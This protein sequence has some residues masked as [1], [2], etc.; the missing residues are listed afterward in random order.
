MP[1][2]MYLGMA[3]CRTNDFH[4]VYRSFLRKQWGSFHPN[5]PVVILRFAIPAIVPI[6]GAVS[7][8]RHSAMPKYILEG[9]WLPDNLEYIA[10]QEW[11]LKQSYVQ[12][13]I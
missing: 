7:F 3:E 5:N 2:N 11:L 4:L 1:S 12:R 13:N 10:I 6:E 9:I 8:V